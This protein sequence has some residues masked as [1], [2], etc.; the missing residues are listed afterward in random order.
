M[1]FL[2]FRMTS[3][4]AVKTI[5]ATLEDYNNDF[6]HLRPKAYDKILEKAERKVLHQYLKAILLKRL[7]FRN[8]EDRKGV[9]EKICN[10]A[11]QLEEFFA[12]LSKTPKKDSFSVLNN[13]A[14]VIRLRDTSMM[15]LEIT[16]LVHKYPDMRR[17]QLINLLLCRG[18]MTRSEAQKMVRDTLGDDHQLRTRPYG[19][20]TDIT[21]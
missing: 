20:F 14:E 17:D 2:S 13:L 12:S 6:V 8:Y 19:I 4:D 18:D 21:S 16:G 1:K 9:A 5:C 7:S 15:S 10:E 11:E 3:S